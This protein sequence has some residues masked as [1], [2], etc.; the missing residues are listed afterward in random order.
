MTFQQTP[1]QKYLPIIKQNIRF[2]YDTFID[3]NP[4]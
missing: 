1:I 4:F 2:L 3:K